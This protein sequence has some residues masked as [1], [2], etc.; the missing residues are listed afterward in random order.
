MK[1]V[2][3]LQHTYTSSDTGEVETKFIGAYSSKENAEKAVKR[4]SSQPG[5]QD[6]PDSFFINEYQ[7]NQDHWNEGFITEQHE[8]LF[9]VWRQD[10]NGN[11]YL[12]KDRITEIDAFNLVREYEGKGHKQSYWVK[13]I[14]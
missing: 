13:E 4:L 2:F 5:F 6:L 14:K 10:D 11:I 9:A 8:P 3:I 7:I 12:V 1:T